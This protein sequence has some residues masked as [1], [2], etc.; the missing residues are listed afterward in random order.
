MLVRLFDPVVQFQTKSGA[1]NTAGR[2]VVYLEGT[3]DLAQI[4]SDEEGHV[5]LSQPAILDNNG[6][7]RG[8]YVESGIKYRLAV[9]TNHGALLFTVR[10][11]VP[12][13]GGGGGGQSLSA[14]LPLKIVNGT[15]NN[16]GTGI[17]CTGENAWAEGHNTTA[18]GEHSHAEGSETIASGANTH[19]EGAAT[20]ATHPHAHAEGFHTEATATSAHAEGSGAK[21]TTTTAHAEGQDTVASGD[22]SHAQGRNSVASGAYSH[23]SG[24]GT[25]ATGQ[26][27]HAVGKYND[28]GSALFVVG[29]GSG[30]NNRKDVFK[31]D[32]DGNSWVMINDV[33]TKVTNVSGGG[34]GG[35]DQ[36]VLVRSD[37]TTAFTNEEYQACVDAVTAGQAVCVQ[38][39][40]NDR[41][42]QAQLTQVE[43]DTGLL[44]FEIDVAN[45]HITYEVS[46]TNNSHTITE[47]DY[48]NGAPIFDTLQDAITWN[49]VLHN[50]DIFETNGFHTSGDGGAARYRVSS[51]GT[52][53]GM[54]IVQLSAGKLAVL[55]VTSEGLYPEQL[56]YVPTKVYADRV[57]CTPT[58]NRIWA[59]CDTVRLHK[60]RYWF[61]DYLTL[62]ASGKIIGENVYGD[63]VSEMSTYRSGDY[64][65]YCE[66]REN[67]IE[68]VVLS[69]RHNSGSLSPVSTGGVGIRSNE[70]L[71]DGAAHFDYAFRHLR[72]MGFRKGME[73]Q[74]TTKWAVTLYDI[75]CS[76]CYIGI[77][78][79]EASFNIDLHK[80]YTDHC[81]YAG[82]NFHGEGV[83]GFYDCNLGSINTAVKVSEY[84]GSQ[85]TDILLTFVNTNFE[86][87]DQSL[88]NIPG[89]YFDIDDALDVILNMYGCRF[90][91]N[92]GVYTVSNRCMK[93]GAKTLV[94]MKGCE[95]RNN[96]GVAQ[97][98]DNFWNENYPCKF[99]L[100]AIRISDN[101]RG[102][103]TAQFTD[104]KFDLCC[105]ETDLTEME[106]TS[107]G[108]GGVPVNNLWDNSNP[109]VLAGYVSESNA[110]HP[111]GFFTLNNSTQMTLA[112]PITNY[113][114]G[115]TIR[116]S[117]GTTSHNRWKYGKIGAIPTATVT[118]LTYV[119]NTSTDS[120]GR[121]Y[122][123][124][125]V[126]AT[127]TGYILIF[128]GSAISSTDMVA[129]AMACVSPYYTPYESY[130]GG[131]TTY[132]RQLRTGLINLDELVAALNLR[133]NSLN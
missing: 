70:W 45:I 64:F 56:G 111:N 99:T 6:R 114:Q 14:S 77:E 10:N 34:G 84:G 102:V 79:G 94:N 96:T 88:V 23:A 98:D 91:Q 28:D 43:S 17:T 119:G 1:L 97:P 42:F 59:L 48:Q 118:D 109:T 89:L 4:Y 69:N 41:T 72:L 22:A 52:A 60:G 33:L 100:G 49:A 57:D 85:Y 26:G 24:Y 124:I 31:V 90:M 93:L 5:P 128:F 127:E 65:V 16:N 27:S 18:S 30:Q 131:T 32:S 47:S 37:M 51:T 75:R 66:N 126:G 83:F 130:Q 2:L 121:T 113:M 86:C 76:Q 9:H 129:D 44:V 62:P 108:G 46:G 8:L 36:F 12:V 19:A 78:F 116:I 123:D 15:I 82:I 81:T 38:F 63:D 7:S 87:D 35:G 73:L 39:G 58:F 67:V 120:S 115:Q 122:S 71:H 103:P 101:C 133:G 68:N 112:I 104:S 20:K 55:Q 61:Y 80:I 3:D 40:R 53:N 54:D 117:A 11:M 107:Q 95:V 13:G 21:A 50:G 74:G 125:P 92:A 132:R 25:R 29:N 110:D 106:I 105:V